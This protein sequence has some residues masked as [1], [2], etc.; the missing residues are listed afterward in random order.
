MLVSEGGLGQHAAK[1]EM[2]N[3]QKLVTFQ[4]LLY[5]LD[6]FYLPSNAMSRVSVV[7]LYLRILTGRTHRAFCWFVIGFLLSNMIAI[8]VAAQVECF[9]LQYTWDRTIQGGHCFNQIVY[10]KVANIPNVVADVMI[11]ALPI[12]TVWNLQTSLSRKGEIAAV[13]FLGSM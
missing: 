8:L 11:L 7:A 13:F 5:I 6:W 1:V 9:P 3:P 2:E 10:Y 4:K 12:P